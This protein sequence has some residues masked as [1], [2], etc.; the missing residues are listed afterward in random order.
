MKAGHLCFNCLPLKNGNCSNSVTT[1]VVVSAN[2]AN[3]VHTSAVTEFPTPVVAAAI[4]TSTSVNDDAVSPP[5][6]ILSIPHATVK[7]L[8]RI[9]CMSRERAALK[10]TEIV[11]LVVRDSQNPDVWQRLFLFPSRCL[12]APPRGGVHRSLANFVNDRYEQ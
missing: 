8:K 11:N 2:T 6:S 9:P 7:I 10:L 3:T 5:I 12:C 4:Q 1:P